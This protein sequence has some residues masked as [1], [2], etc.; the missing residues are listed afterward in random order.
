MEYQKLGCCKIGI[1][2]VPANVVLNVSLL[3]VLL[4]AL[5]V[6]YGYCI[7]CLE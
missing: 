7:R 2:C 4:T 3:S 6:E 1:I 5:N